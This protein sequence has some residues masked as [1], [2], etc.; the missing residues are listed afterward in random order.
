[1]NKSMDMKRHEV[2]EQ[3]AG[4]EGQMQVEFREVD[5]FNLWVSSSVGCYLLFV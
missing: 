5:P 2:Q 3:T 4:D 1:M